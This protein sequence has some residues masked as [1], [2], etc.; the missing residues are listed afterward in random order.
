MER[1]QLIDN[2]RRDDPVRIVFIAG[3]G[4]SGS[5]LMDRILGSME[6]NFSAGELSLLWKTARD[7]QYPCSC[8]AKLKACPFW[9]AVFDEVFGTKDHHRDIGLTELLLRSTIK[10]R[11]FPQL[12]LQNL[13][14][15]ALQSRIG[16]LLEILG[17]LYMAIRR[18]SG[19][20]VVVDSSKSA[21]YG[22]LLSEIPGIDLSVVHMLRDSRAVAYSQVRSRYDANVG[23]RTVTRSPVRSALGWNFYN[24]LVE[25]WRLADRPRYRRISYED[26]ARSPRTIVEHLSED[27]GLPVVLDSFVSETRIALN[28]GHTCAGNVMRFKEGEIDIQL[29]REWRVRQRL[30]DRIL[31]TAATWPLLMRYGYGIGR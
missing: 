23:K 3:Y 4:R 6:G 31:V 22:V 17:R 19:A 5:T 27:L 28:S 16:E 1:S 7:E 29:D 24:S 13:R 25:V 2:S 15:E 11:R 26:L 14:S 30:A 9:V 8:R 21:L 12:L 18:V 20:E 10:R